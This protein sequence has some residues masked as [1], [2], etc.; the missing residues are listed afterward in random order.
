LLKEKKV[1]GL[2]GLVKYPEDDFKGRLETTQGRA[3]ICFVKGEV[4]HILSFWV[5]ED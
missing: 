1:E 5:V 3:N 2:F 4:S